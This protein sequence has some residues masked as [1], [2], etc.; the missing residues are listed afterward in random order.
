MRLDKLLWLLRLASSRRLAQDWIV[1]G[2]I[3]L[4]GRRVERA[5]IAIKPGDVFVLPMP[6][7]VRVIEL[8][9]LPTRRGPAAEARLCYRALDG[10]RPNPIA[11][12]TSIT[13]EGK[14][15]P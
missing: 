9:T 4:N 5:S 12:G 1:A 2:H 10:P 6:N 11:A 15:P 7:E 13:P 8:L 3:R 14:P